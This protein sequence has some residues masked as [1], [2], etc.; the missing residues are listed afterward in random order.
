MMQGFMLYIVLIL[1]FFNLTLHCIVQANFR[2]GGC[3][4]LCC[5]WR[6]YLFLF[7]TTGL[8]FA[9]CFMILSFLLA[10]YSYLCGCIYNHEFYVSN[11][12]N[13]GSLLI[14]CQVIVGYLLAGSIIG[15]GGL[16]FISE[17]V[18]VCCLVW[19]SIRTSEGEII[20]EFRMEDTACS[21]VGCEIK[22]N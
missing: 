15:P 22:L 12:G 21:Y 14:I 5:H 7:G 16:K 3:Y 10:P 1:L 9:A 13:D 6:N 20:C 17:M 4:S 8:C 2:L 18:Q 19:S 11:C